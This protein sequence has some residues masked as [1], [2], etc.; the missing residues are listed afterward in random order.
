MYPRFSGPPVK[1]RARPLRPQTRGERVGWPLL[2][3][4]P[5]VLPERS[6]QPAPCRLPGTAHAAGKAGPQTPGGAPSAP[7]SA[8]IAASAA[9]WGDAP[10]GN[11]LRRAP[12]QAFE[13]LFTSMRLSRLPEPESVR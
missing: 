7:L 5:P 13:P 9:A 10:P 6:T 12:P 4:N 2:G 1:P 3:P 11:R 8:I